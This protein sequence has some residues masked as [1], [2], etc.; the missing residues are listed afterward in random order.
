MPDLY[1]KVLRLVKLPFSECPSNKLWGGGDEE[2]SMM[3]I[4]DE[5]ILYCLLINDVSG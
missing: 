2:R 3:M 4:E 5:S 1:E